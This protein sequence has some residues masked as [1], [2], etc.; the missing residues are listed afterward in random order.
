[1]RILV[2]E[3]NQILAHALQSSLKC[4]G[5]DAEYETNANKAEKRIMLHHD[6]YDLIILDWMLPDKEGIEILSR[7]RAKGI[8]TPVLMLT[9]K[10]ELHD[11]VAGFAKGADDY[12]TKPFHPEELL[13]RVK[14]LLRRPKQTLPQKLIAGGITL[15]PFSRRV[16]AGKKEIPLTHKEFTLLEYLMRNPDRALSREEIFSH[17]WDFADESFSNV[18]NVYIHH[19]RKKLIWNGK[20]TLEAIPGVGYR[21]NTGLPAPFYA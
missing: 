4:E 14:A 18:I 2:V 5:F 10:R 11:K 1:M 20:N 16:H 15:D 13:A 3:D 19:L 12:V 21:L 6:D 17:A 9:A 8:S 7:M